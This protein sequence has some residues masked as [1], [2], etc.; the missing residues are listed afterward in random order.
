MTLTQ[1]FPYLLIA[2][3]NDDGV[4][5]FQTASTNVTLVLG[6]AVL[7]PFTAGYNSNG[8][9]VSSTDTYN[10]LTVSYTRNAFLY[11]ITPYNY[12]IYLPVVVTN[13]DSTITISHCKLIM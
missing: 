10:G 11:E 4:L 5:Q 9:A 6:T 1:S 2:G 13:I 7:L 8:S 3:S 12:G